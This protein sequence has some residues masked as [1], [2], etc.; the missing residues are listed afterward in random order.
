MEMGCQGPLEPESLG[1]SAIFV[2][3]QRKV[4]GAAARQS[5]Q[6]CTDT[7]PGWKGPCLC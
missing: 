1:I 2:D 4:T 7:V 6:A 3:V 5:V